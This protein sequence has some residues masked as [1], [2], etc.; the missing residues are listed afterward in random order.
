MSAQQ[1]VQLEASP[2]LAHA[3]QL[4]SRMPIAERVHRLN[5]DS[6]VH[7][8]EDVLRQAFARD[9]EEIARW[10]PQTW[11]KAVEWFG[12]LPFLREGAH[13]INGGAGT[14]RA[15][16]AT[17]DAVTWRD[18]SLHWREEWDRRASLCRKPGD[19]AAALAPITG[20][21]LGAEA[22]PGN[23]IPRTLGWT[24]EAMEQHFLKVF[25]MYGA[26]PV[27]V[28]AYLSLGILDNERLRGILVNRVVF[29]G[30]A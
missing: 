16:G 27:S 6:D 29:A 20:R 8:V 15:R 11:R 22:A 14:D 17:E 19:L 18:V 12:L 25:R 24:W 2:D 1:W 26:G 13:A 30:A 5:S 3:L 10:C 23:A 28:F 7:V 9:V 21:F 4:A